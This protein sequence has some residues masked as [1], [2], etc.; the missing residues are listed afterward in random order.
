MLLHKLFDATVQR[1]PG[2]LALVC[3]DVR[4]SYA[5]I[6]QRSRQL[7]R[8]LRGQGIASG[9]RVGLFLENGPDMVV[10]I[11]ALLRLGA[12][13]MAFNPQTKADKLGAVL[14]RTRAAA[15]LTQATLAT[16]WRRAA[17]AAPELRLLLVGGRGWQPA[18]ARELPWPDGVTDDGSVLIDIDADIDARALAF[19]SHTS[20]TTGLPKGVMLTHRNLAGI[21]GTI[22]EYLALRQ[23]D[24][25]LSALPLSFNYG[26][27]QLLTAFAT[28]ATLVLE[29][30]FAFPV[31]I[32]ET[33]ARERATVFPAV[34]TMYAML[35]TL[36]DMSRWDLSSLRLMTS[37]SAPLPEPL[38]RQLR[39]RLPAVRLYVMYGQTECT[40]ISYL[41]PEQIDRRLGSVGRGLPGQTCWLIDEHGQR[42][43]HGS[44]GELVVQGDHVMAGYWEDSER[45]A[46]KLF[47]DPASGRI[48]MRTGDLF[49][50]DAEGWLYFIARKDDI[51]KTR[52][53][54]V[55]PH[56][57]EQAIL[58]IPG[59]RECAVS[60]VA[61]ALLGQAVHA[62]VVLEDGAALSERDI[63][64]HCLARLE[65]HMAPKHVAF[66]D[67]LPR[68]DTG[69]VSKHLLA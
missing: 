42:L 13:C 43:P 40:R 1:Q 31:K 10:A 2:K 53:E 45:T 49:R 67:A 3:G 62:H 60:G 7:A 9:E 17:E 25:I 28:G 37:A 58:G 54:K 24:V 33:L 68:T 20:G 14:A 47:L 61:D 59:V 38:L 30:S 36:Q 23:D 4:L 15:L 41:P 66:L 27:T 16:T 57:V 8:Y 26:L 46:D 29:R 6:D 56:E 21:T 12:V 11:L 63:I 48:A 39:K 55:S 35:M 34:P 52:G 65:N 69:K 32:L 22:A 44:S 19:I 64:R 51:I 50:S 18:S 5:Q